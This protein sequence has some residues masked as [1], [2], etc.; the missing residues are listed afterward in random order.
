[1]PHIECKNLQFIYLFLKA[2]VIVGIDLYIFV[3]THQ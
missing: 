1:M 3:K 2:G